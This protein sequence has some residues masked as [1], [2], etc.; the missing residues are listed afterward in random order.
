MIEPPK[1]LTDKLVI[2]FLNME[3]K[4]KMRKQQIKKAL[5]RIKRGEI[6]CFLRNNSSCQNSGFL[7]S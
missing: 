1:F 7:T 2:R 5:N 4:P 6:K 3:H